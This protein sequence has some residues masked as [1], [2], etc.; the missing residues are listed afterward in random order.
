[1]PLLSRH[2]KPAHGLNIVF[3]HLA[4]T[5]VHRKTGSLKLAQE[6]LGHS[7]VSTTA[8]IYTDVDEADMVGAADALAQA[9]GVSCGKPVVE[10]VAGAA[11]VN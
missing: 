2:A 9:L 1:M 10:S 6:Q 5:L 3:R 7:N 4:A 11:L 8:N